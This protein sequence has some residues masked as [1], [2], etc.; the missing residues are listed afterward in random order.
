MNILFVIGAAVIGWL[1]QER[2]FASQMARSGVLGVYC[3]IVAI[4]SLNYDKPLSVVA[5]SLAF[6]C[7]IVVL[8]IKLTGPVKPQSKATPKK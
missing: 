2:L 3:L 8:V 7:L 1:L 4:I 6:V 5:W